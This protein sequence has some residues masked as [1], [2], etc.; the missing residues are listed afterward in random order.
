M[1]RMMQV[2]LFRRREAGNPRAGKAAAT[3]VDARSTSGPAA[4]RFSEDDCA[5]F[6][7]YARERDTRYPQYRAFVRLVDETLEALSPAASSCVRYWLMPT[8][9][10]TLARLNGSGT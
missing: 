4:S 7:R 3:S 2:S 6:A 5:V 8:A 1:M 9:K 10:R